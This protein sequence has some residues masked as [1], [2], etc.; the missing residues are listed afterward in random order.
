MASKFSI[1]RLVK[2]LAISVHAEFDCRKDVSRLEP[3]KLI[4]LRAAILGMMGLV[5]ICRP[6]PLAVGLE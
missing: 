2:D 5:E 1:S 3:I 4:G 6:R